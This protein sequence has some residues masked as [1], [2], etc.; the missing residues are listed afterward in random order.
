MTLPLSLLNEMVITNGDM[1]ADITSPALDLKEAVSYSIQAY[2]TGTAPE[3][4]L[5]VQGSNDDSHYTS[6][7]PS[8]V[9]VSEDD[10]SILIN[11]EKHAY[12]YI[13]VFYIADSGVGTLNVRINAKRG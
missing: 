7:L 1:S 11:V 8:N 13:K 10:N 6:I 4:T 12:A 9:V 2:W 3:G 5:D